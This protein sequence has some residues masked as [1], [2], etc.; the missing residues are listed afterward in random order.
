M[1]NT[2]KNN[3]IYIEHIKK[4]YFWRTAFF[5]LVILTAGIVIGGASMSIFLTHK[6]ASS[7]PRPVYESLMPRLDQIL[8]LTQVQSNKIKPILDGYMQHLQEIREDG[9]LEI[10]STLDQ[11]NRE[12]SPIL[13]EGQKVVWSRELLRIQNELNPEPQRAAPRGAGGGRRRG[14][15]QPGPGPGGM[16]G[17]RF[18]RGQMMRSGMGGRRGPQF[19]PVPVGPNSFS[20][21]INENEAAT[22]SFDSNAVK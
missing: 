5:G 22:N 19:Q 8:G 14:G 10:A 1:E 18:G 6:L 11:M 7:K 17:R 12:I 15:E 13:A 9:R 3:N 16:G 20:S 2:E 21:D 4:I